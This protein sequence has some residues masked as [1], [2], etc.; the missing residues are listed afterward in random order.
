MA[1]VKLRFPW[2]AQGAES[3][4]V[5]IATPMAGGNRGMVFLPEVDDEV[6]VAFENGDLNRPYVL[7]GLWNGEDSPPETN[8]DGQ[9]NIRK[10]CS[11]SGHE[12]IFND[13]N[14]SRSEKI[15][16]HTNAGNS[17]VLDDSSGSEKVEI[18]D[19]TGNNVIK[20]DAVQ[21][22][23]SMSSAMKIKL[24]AQMIEINSQGNMTLQAGAVMTIQG[25]MVRIN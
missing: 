19:K 16:I 15:E 21:N 24:D 10:I 17:I 2:L 18:K 13:D 4:W 5:R 7:G 11:R 1:R 12:I 14:T 25:S 23:V 22:E 3:N 8:S 9:N 20:L 6:L